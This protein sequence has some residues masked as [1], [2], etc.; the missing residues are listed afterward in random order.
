MPPM[1]HSAAPA[2]V[3]LGVD[4]LGQRLLAKSVDEIDDP[5]P[6][7]HFIVDPDQPRRLAAKRAGVNDV[8][9]KLALTQ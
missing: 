5:L 1:Q 8:R 7:Q 6:A 4:V 2:I 9:R 3:M